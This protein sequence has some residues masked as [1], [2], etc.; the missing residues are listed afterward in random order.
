MNPLL[1]KRIYT[2]LAYTMLALAFGVFS[3]QIYHD[4]NRIFNIEIN[5]MDFYSFL[6]G[7]IFSF[8]AI[9]ILRLVSRLNLF[10]VYHDKIINM[11]RII[12]YVLIV[13][14]FLFWSSLLMISILF[15]IPNI[16]ID[17]MIYRFF[18]RI[19]L[20]SLLYSSSVNLF[21]FS[22]AIRLPK[23]EKNDEI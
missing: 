15:V 4:F 8:S 17:I 2:I 13:F 10:S 5:N 22:L 7:I 3:M 21:F 18:A 6:S 20:I 14:M 9:F 11:I 23:K 1:K 16:I 12:L 19:I